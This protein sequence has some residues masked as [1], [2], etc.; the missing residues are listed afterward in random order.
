MFVGQR[1][2]RLRNLRNRVSHHENL[3]NV[4]VD[5]R[6]RDMN[7]LLSSVRSNYPAW[8]MSRS[9]VRAVAKLDPRLSS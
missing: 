3:I 9:R 7:T 5:H 6:L 4:D 2:E 1:M 8:A